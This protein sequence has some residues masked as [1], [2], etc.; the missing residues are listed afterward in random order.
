MRATHIVKNKD[1]I[2]GDNRYVKYYEALYNT[3]LI[4]NLDIDFD[5]IVYRKLK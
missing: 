3:D 1:K 2:M 4:D 5:R